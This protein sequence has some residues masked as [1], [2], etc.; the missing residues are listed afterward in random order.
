[1]NTPGMNVTFK[2]KPAVIRT[3]APAGEVLL[4]LLSSCKSASG[5]SWPAGTLLRAVS[6]GAKGYT[7]TVVEGIP[8]KGGAL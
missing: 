7:Y 3:S 2:S 1:M 6:Y 5:L 4:R 8:S